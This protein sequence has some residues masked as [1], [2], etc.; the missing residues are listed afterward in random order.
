MT[1]VNVPCTRDCPGRSPTCHGSCDRYAAYVAYR[2]HI[3]AARQHD[4]EM[5]RA[6]VQGA[7]KIKREKFRESKRR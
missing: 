6:L 4:T 1:P 2:E 7:A 5:T 3:R